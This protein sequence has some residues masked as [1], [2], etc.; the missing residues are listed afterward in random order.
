[1]LNE[2]DW[3]DIPGYYQIVEAIV[4]ELKEREVYDYPDSLNSATVSFIS[5]VRLL[6]D[7]VQIVFKKT[8]AYDAFTVNKSL[9]LV[10]SWLVC[11]HKNN[12]LIPADFDF[13]FFFKAV[14]MLLDL[15]HGTSTAKVIW[16]L[17]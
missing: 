1:M 15:D 9:E 12:S 14:H 2:V 13:V 10:A 5:N 7:F 11:I 8:H 4:L 17:Y 16:L 3:S 6:N